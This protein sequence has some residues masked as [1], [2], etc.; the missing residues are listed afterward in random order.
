MNE[1]KFKIKIP[2]SSVDVGDVNINIHLQTP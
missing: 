2:T 1:Q